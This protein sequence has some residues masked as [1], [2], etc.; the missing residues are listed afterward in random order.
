MPEAIPRKQQPYSIKWSI[1]GILFS[2]AGVATDPQKVQCMKEWPIPTTV[3]ALRGLLDLTGYYKKF[4]KGYGFISKPLTSLLKKDGF[5]WNE[6]AEAAFNRTDQKSLQHILDQR[7]DSVLQQKW[8]TKVLGLSYEVEYKKGNDNR[9][10]GALSRREHDQTECQNYAISTQLPLW[11]QELQS[12]YEEDT[13]F[14]P[15]LQVKILDPQSLPEYKY[16]SGIL[17]KGNR[18]CVGS[19]GGINDTIIKAMHDSAL[20]GHSGI[21][22]T[23]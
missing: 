13:L 22:G 1:W 20:G 2:I 23:F 11:I 7:V 4:I 17:R 6:E 12:S 10:A 21:T 19:Y 8:I 14:Q 9:A 3:K 15:I 16:E 18:L 5:L